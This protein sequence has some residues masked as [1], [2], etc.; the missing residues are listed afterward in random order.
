MGRPPIE[1]RDDMRYLEHEGKVPSGDEHGSDVMTIIV[2]M[3]ISWELF[4]V[5]AMFMVWLIISDADVV[6][7][8]MRH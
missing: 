5:M 7:L 3:V 1:F 4:V 8:M 6:K 2:M